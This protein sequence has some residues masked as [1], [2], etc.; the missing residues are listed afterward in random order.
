MEK[1]YEKMAE[2]AYAYAQVQNV[3]AAHTYHYRAQ[4]QRQEL[5]NYWAQ[6]VDDIAYAHGDSAFVGRE[7]VYHYYAD[8]NEYMRAE[9]LK[10]LAKIFPD[11]EV[12]PENEGMGDMVIHMYTTPYI[13][14]AGDGKTA[15]GVWYSP[16][17]CAEL[18][19]DG[20]PVPVVLLERTGADFLCEN[21]VW[22][23]WH[24]RSFGEFMARLE[25]NFLLQKP[26]DVMVRTVSDKFPKANVQLPKQEQPYSARAVASMTPK[27][28]QPYETWS[29]DISILK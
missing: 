13:E 19:L 26:Q 24:L 23:L 11:V 28:P 27:L 21:G 1:N 10:V 25:S 8:N 22:K 9:K 4:M 12:C 16:A 6:T 2:F 7:T 15:K 3:I 18:D 17:L 20:K 14:V 5:D 29:E